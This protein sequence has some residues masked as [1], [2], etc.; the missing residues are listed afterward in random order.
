MTWR[1]FPAGITVTN[2][3]TVLTYDP[4][5]T[6]SVL[7]S[8]HLADID[9]LLVSQLNLQY[10]CLIFPQQ[11]IL[12][13]KIRHNTATK[14]SNATS[15]LSYLDVFIFKVAWCTGRRHT[16]SWSRHPCAFGARWRS[17]FVVSRQSQ[18]G[19]RQ[20]S[21]WISDGQ[22]NS[23][24]LDWNGIVSACYFYHGICNILLLKFVI[25]Y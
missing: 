7:A 2:G 3:W 23:L 8:L 24:L 12:H 18:Q 15:L 13:S 10:S 19:H 17:A 4:Y 6:G 14:S 20:T 11:F 9:S 5:S 22:S 16:Y 1:L 21:V 25:S